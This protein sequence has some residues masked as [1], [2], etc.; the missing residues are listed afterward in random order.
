MSNL[1][2]LIALQK[3]KNSG[4]PA[5]EAPADKRVDRVEAAAPRAE[6]K[7]DDSQ[8]TGPIP[9]A[10]V[11]AAPAKKGL[12]LNL[13]KSGGVSGAVRKPP[14]QSDS[15]ARASANKPSAGSGLDGF[16]EFSLD[17]LAGFDESTAPAL[18]AQDRGQPSGFADEIEATAPDRDLPADL[19][20][21]Q[22]MFVEQLDGIYQILNDPEMFAQSVRIIMMELQEN[23][24]YEKLVSDQDVHTMIRAMRNTMGLARIKKQ[25]KSRSAKN[26]TAAKK[27]AGTKG[28]SADALALLDAM[29][30]DDDD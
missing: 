13:L 29:G 2:K 17:D 25:S 7:P 16:A 10:P 4:V 20:A 14:A 15:G 24:E 27:A 18:T 11:S 1:G 3:A 12:G 23:P 5:N 6:T 19:S 9:S 8:S 30:G 21:Q 28:L 26:S 22:L